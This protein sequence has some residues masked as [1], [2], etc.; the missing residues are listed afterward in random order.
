MCLII[1]QIQGRK[2]HKINSR[3]SLLEVMALHPLLLINE[4]DMLF[5]KMIA[6]F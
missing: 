4:F 6:D 3:K 5:E 2:V 1:N